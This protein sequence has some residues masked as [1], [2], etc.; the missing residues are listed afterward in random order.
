PNACGGV[1]EGGGLCHILPGHRL[2]KKEKLRNQ[3]EE[4]WG[5]PKGRIPPKP[6][7]HTMAM[8]TA[9]N[10]GKIKGVWINCTSPVQSLPNASI[11]TKG[12]K[13]EDVFI[14]CSDIFPTRTTEVANLVL[15]TAFHFEKTGVYGCT[16][17]RSQL[18]QKALDAPKG[19]M[20]EVW[21]VREWA[22]KLAEKMKDPVIAQCVKPFED[23]E[24]DYQ[25]PKAIWQEYSQK[26]TK[27]RD[28]DL[29]G[30]TY[31]VLSEMADGVQ[32]PAP[33]EKYAR[34]GGTVKK[35]VVGKDPL[36]E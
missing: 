21:I 36:A 25:L 18:T 20:P 12:M 10:E 34:T 26:A 33:T 30:A 5:I 6:G 27:G 16:E 15:P 13:Q 24:P 28:N 3:M 23:L 11:Y 9:L 4:I 29:R 22:K 19:A 1:R 32:W 35:F 8:F 14:I 7:Y 2:V 31:E 17:R